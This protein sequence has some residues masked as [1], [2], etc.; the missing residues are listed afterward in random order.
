MAQHEQEPAEWYG[1][2]I[3]AVNL[4]KRF[5]KHEAVH[6][7]SLRVPQGAAYALIGGN[8][9][10]K[11]TLLKMLVNILQPDSGEASILGVDSR[12]LSYR[13]F[14]HIGFVSENQQLPERLTVAQ[15]FDAWRPFYPSWDKALESEMRRRLE[16]PAG[17]KLDKL[18]HG[19]RMKTM[20]ASALAFRPQL[21]VLDE[22]LS[23]LDPL[24][25]DEILEGLLSHA[26]E[27]T[28]VISSHELTEIESWT[29]HV[30]FMQQGR[31][32]FE[33]PV[34]EL[35]SRFREVN[36]TLARTSK[37]PQSPLPLGWLAPEVSG[38]TLRFVDTRFVG[39]RELVQQLSTR[40]GQIERFDAQ[41]LSLKD[42]SKTLL[43][44]S[45]V[46]PAT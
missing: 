14:Q 29:T 16:L 23:G 12:N 41:P 38:Q 4:S 37:A 22:P 24:V 31:I 18:S 8:G 36:V 33:E 11:T 6:S 1:M 42:I 15:Y 7:A 45:R 32:M 46:E 34:D 26:Q 40:Y 39:D 19:M 9:A 13:D 10:G 35:S 5:A 43:R 20:L 3:K 44:A 28:I 30:G 27:T 25:R 21:L 17:R 2:M